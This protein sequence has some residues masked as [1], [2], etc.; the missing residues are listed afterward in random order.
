MKKSKSQ[1]IKSAPV[2]IMTSKKPRSTSKKPRSRSKRPRSAPERSKPMSIE[3]KRAIS[4]AKMFHEKIYE[5]HEV[6]LNYMGQATKLLSKARMKPHKPIHEWGTGHLEPLKYHYKQKKSEM[7]AH[8]DKIYEIEKQIQKLEK[9]RL[10]DFNLFMRGK[11]NIY[12]IEDPD[13]FLG[14]LDCRDRV[15]YCSANKKLRDKCKED[16]IEDKYIMPCKNEALINKKIKQLVDINSEF[17][18]LNDYFEM[19]KVHNQTYASIM[20]LDVLEYLSRYLSYGPDNDKLENME[21]TT[22][23]YIKFNPAKQKWSWLV[24][25]VGEEIQDLFNVD[26]AFGDVWGELWP[27][28]IFLNFIN[29][30]GVEDPL[31]PQD[32]MMEILESFSAPRRPLPPEIEERINKMDE[33][34]SGSL[35]WWAIALDCEIYVG[36]KNDTSRD[37]WGKAFQLLHQLESAF[38][39]VFSGE[40]FIDELKPETH[41]QQHF[42]DELNETYGVNSKVRDIN[43]YLKSNGQDKDEIYDRLMRIKEAFLKI[44]VS[45][46]KDHM[47]PVKYFE[48]FIDLLSFKANPDRENKLV[49]INDELNQMVQERKDR[50]KK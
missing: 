32:S 47:L 7:M 3:K 39:D 17:D 24:E 18:G 8:A 45:K 46:L 44:G 23:F 27:E 36:S 12:G 20:E 15:S 9:K 42:K 26:A 21:E 6:D 14:L 1:R 33:Y 5:P 34:R 50:D 49:L 10:D 31:I 11:E 19:I 30:M 29:G 4:L 41:T 25:L 2:K 38:L 43:R 16:A 28:D 40:R 37:Q 22:S 35:T 48:E 13:P